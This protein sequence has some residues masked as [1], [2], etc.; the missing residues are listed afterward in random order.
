V[1]QEL[2]EIPLLQKVKQLDYNEGHR[3]GKAKLL[4]WLRFWLPGQSS[5]SLDMKSLTVGQ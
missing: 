2:R 4:A 3:Q 1:G 5:T